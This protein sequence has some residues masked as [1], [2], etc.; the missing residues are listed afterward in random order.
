MRW[1]LATEQQSE[2][3]TRTNVSLRLIGEALRKIVRVKG[4]FSVRS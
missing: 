4:A 3:E 1:D 2:K